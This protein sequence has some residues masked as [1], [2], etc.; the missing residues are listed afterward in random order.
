MYFKRYLIICQNH[1]KW[2]F[3]LCKTALRGL[4]FDEEGT[5]IAIGGRQMGEAGC[6]KRGVNN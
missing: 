1:Q 5:P 2:F 6:L 3:P 4:V